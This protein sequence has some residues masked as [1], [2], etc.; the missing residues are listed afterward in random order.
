VEVLYRNRLQERRQRRNAIWGAWTGAALVAA[1]FVTYAMGWWP[2][3]SFMNMRPATSAE[4]TLLRTA[5]VL[6]STTSDRVYV[7]TGDVR[8]HTKERMTI[9]LPPGMHWKSGALNR[10]SLVRYH[11]WKPDPT[12]FKRFYDPFCELTTAISLLPADS[13][14]APVGDKCIGFLAN[15]S[16]SRAADAPTR[17]SGA[18]EMQQYVP[19]FDPA[20]DLPA[21]M[22]FGDRD[23]KS[24]NFP[25]FRWTDGKAQHTLVLVLPIKLASFS[26]DYDRLRVVGSQ[27]VIVNQFCHSAAYPAFPEATPY[28]FATREALDTLHLSC[29]VG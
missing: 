11:E 5:G 10:V 15:Q 14:G 12:Q 29:A 4:V 23:G 27:A 19:G 16:D 2:F 8:I 18:K 3:N 22:V 6:P 7:A 26:L 28:N 20:A 25:L 9:V 21:T 13:G 1:F 17:P 24:V